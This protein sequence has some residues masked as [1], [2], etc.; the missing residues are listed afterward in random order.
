MTSNESQV[1]MFYGHGFF[2]RNTTTTEGVKV[3]TFHP[4][5]VITREWNKFFSLKDYA[6]FYQDTELKLQLFT[7]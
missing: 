2:L 3:F 7:S 1:I 6:K 5:N 4:M